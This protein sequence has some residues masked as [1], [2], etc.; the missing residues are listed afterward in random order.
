MVPFCTPLPLCGALVG[1]TF[2]P[3]VLGMRIS[4]QRIDRDPMS[5]FRRE[6]T[7]AWSGGMVARAALSTALPPP[8]RSLLARSFSFHPPTHPCSTPRPGPRCTPLLTHPAPDRSVGWWEN[9]RAVPPAHAADPHP[10]PHHPVGKPSR[11]S[12]SVLQLRSISSY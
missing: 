8:R 9:Q 5:P 3:R 7:A 11:L 12:P 2:P 4:G 6:V 10:G 1:S